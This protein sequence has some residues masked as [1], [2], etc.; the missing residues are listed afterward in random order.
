MKMDTV[1]KFDATSGVKMGLGG[2]ISPPILRIPSKSDKYYLC[3]VRVYR[4]A[5]TA[6]QTVRMDH[7]LCQECAEMVFIRVSM[8]CG[9]L[10][11]HF[12][13]GGACWKSRKYSHHWQIARN[14]QKC[15]NI[16]VWSS[17]SPETLLGPPRQLEC[18]KWYVK[19]VPK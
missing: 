6:A 18:T 14:Y 13:P 10:V 12:R 1:V 2:S 7:L 19:S 11:L 3:R 15:T 17:A 16:V 4:N 9:R 8:D 5:A